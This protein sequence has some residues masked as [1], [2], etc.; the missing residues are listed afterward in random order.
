M[1]TYLKN[2]PGFLVRRSG[3]YDDKLYHYGIKGQKWGIRRFQNKDGSLTDEGAARK[4]QDLY[5][6]KGTIVKR[7][8]IDRMDRT[9]D[10]KKYVSINQDDHSKW[11]DYLGYG[12]LNRGIA[13]YNQTYK[14]TKDLKVMSST[15]QGE[16]Y[17]K[18]L[19]DTKFK[20]KVLDDI[21]Y[22]N[23]VLGIEPAKDNDYAEI[24]SRNI[25][26]QTETGKTFIKEVLKQNYDAVVDTHGTNV[27]KNPVIILNSDSN[28]AKYTEPEYTK[29]VQ[30]YLEKYYS[31]KVA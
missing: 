24:I 2:K 15:K 12:Y 10:D 3:I 14:T 21:K 16:L 19:L 20:N 30:D 9:N 22:A 6:K 8:S 18:M 23:N 29:A 28:L 5:I 25:A 27:S 11:E 31:Q 13:T 26:A 7:V 1:N 4:R 17:A